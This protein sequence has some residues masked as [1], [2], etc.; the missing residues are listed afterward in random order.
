MIIIKC[1]HCGKEAMTEKEQLHMA[2]PE[3]FFERKY[4]LCEKCNLEYRSLLIKFFN[5]KNEHS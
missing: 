2:N 4:Y 1:D 5:I 3:V